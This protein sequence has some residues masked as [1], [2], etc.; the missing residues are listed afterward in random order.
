[1]TALLASVAAGRSVL[2]WLLADLF[3]TCP[4]KPL[5][6]RLSRDLP[7]TAAAEHPMMRELA[8]LREALPQDE[9]A[10]TA[11]AVEYTRLFGAVSR[12][13]GPPP[14]YESVHRNAADCAAVNEFYV[15]AGLVTFDVTAPP[16]HLGTE[17]RF[18]ALLCHGESAA[19]RG[20][21]AKEARAALENEHEFLDQHLLAWAPAYLETLE[22]E[23][24]HPFYRALAGTARRIVHADR[25]MIDDLFAEVG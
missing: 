20:G 12:D 14:P 23:A 11:L 2:Y 18:L 4:D 7:S 3:L 16:D 8:V 17:L 6:A 10:I 25:A 21:R 5:V 22:R 13:D 15:N 1:M 19:W 24:R 9:P